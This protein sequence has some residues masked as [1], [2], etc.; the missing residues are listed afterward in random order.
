MAKVKNGERKILAQSN[1][2]GYKSVSL[3]EG[4]AQK[5]F[6]VHRLVCAAFLPRDERRPNVN[7][8]D[9]NKANNHIEN[10]EWVTQKE[11]IDHARATGLILSPIDYSDK[12]KAAAEKRRAFNAAHR[13]MRLCFHL[14]DDQEV[15]AK[16]DSV[17][18]KSKYIKDLI[19]AD[20]AKTK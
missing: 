9:G 18:N 5:T 1:Q 19:K 3:R 8:K 10:L 14:V 13:E 4:G 12:I 17:E 11:N 20:I 7:H 6:L 15:I 2:Y 16:L